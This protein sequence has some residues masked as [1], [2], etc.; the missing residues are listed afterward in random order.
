V[1]GLRTRGRK[2]SEFERKIDLWSGT[3][4][5]KTRKKWQN[6]CCCLTRP[7]TAREDKYRNNWRETYFTPTPSFKNALDTI[8][9]FAFSTTFSKTYFQLLKI[10]L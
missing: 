4:E 8:L 7:T 6:Y 3:L 1:R 9:G 5:L 2:K 10:C